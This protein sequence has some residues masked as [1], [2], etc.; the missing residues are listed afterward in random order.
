MIKEMQSPL[1]LNELLS[2]MPDDGNL[3]YFINKFWL[4]N[5]L[6]GLIPQWVCTVVKII[7]KCLYLRRRVVPE[8]AFVASIFIVAHACYLEFRRCH[9]L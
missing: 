8:I 7:C 2:T 1:R 3:F 5:V 6:H 9:V 4:V